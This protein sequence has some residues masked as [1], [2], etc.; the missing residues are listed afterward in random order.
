MFVEGLD[1]I[2]EESDRHTGRIGGPN[3]CEVKPHSKPWIVNLQ[4]AAICSGTL[5]SRSIVLTAA[6][7]TCGEELS[8]SRCVT[9]IS[10][11]NSSVELVHGVV[12]GDHNQ[13]EIDEGERFIEK[14]RIVAHEKFITGKFK[15]I[16]KH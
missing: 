13:F 6:H 8:I 9:K 10:F 5:V 4:G 11:G 15:N 12:V 16:E 14:S 2:T 7:C 3:A 1:C